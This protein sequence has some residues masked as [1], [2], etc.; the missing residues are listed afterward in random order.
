M[1]SIFKKKYLPL[2]LVYFAYGFS[3]LT[4]VTFT[5]LKKNHFTLTAL[6]W[7]IVGIWAS[8][9]WS[10]K[11][12][13]GSIIDRFTIFKSNRKAYIYLGSILMILGNLTIIDSLS[14]HFFSNQ[15]LLMSV[16]G[17]LFASG[18]VFADLIADTLSV[19]VV[20]PN[21]FEKELTDVSI[22]SR[23]AL[24]IGSVGAALLTGWLAQT[25]S[26]ITVYMIWMVVPILSMS[27][28]FFIKV[29][30]NVER[31]N[32]DNIGL[33]SSIIFASLVVLFIA[34]FGIDKS[35]I[36]IFS[37]TLSYVIYLM[38]S[39]RDSI[40]TEHRKFF[41]LACIAVFLF[42]VSPSAGDGVDWWLMNKFGLNEAFFGKLRIV[43]TVSTLIILS[44]T[45]R[46]LNGASIIKALIIFT[47]MDLIL[48]LPIIFIY[49]G[50][51]FGFEPSHILLVD[52]AMAAPLANLAMIP[53]N[54]LLGIYTPDNKRA[55][56]MAI[57]A[58]FV[59]LALMSGDLISKELNRIFIVT[60]TDHSQLGKLLISC[61]S[62]SVILSI[63]GILIFF[64]TKRPRTK[65]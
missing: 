26:A 48:S 32:K 22:L 35:Q 42:R 20:D 17:F 60:Q 6:E 3:A 51:T 1:I 65:N 24:I 45:A 7:G 9:P 31:L 34:F 33:A 30:E 62:I 52:T 44:L 29:R 39:M 55:T 13:Y 10:I 41:Y 63:M 4:S 47:I 21:N 56:Y 8:L 49:Y 11:I 14:T 27:G 50:Y 43:S 16:G 58:S 15:L 18:C 57:T 59:N 64:Y 53:L 37:L 12:V 61:Q 28:C 38:Y 25:Y 23:Y 5:F 36:W 54:V 19:E 2:L 40:S 46:F